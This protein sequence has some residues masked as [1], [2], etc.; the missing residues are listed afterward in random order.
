[1]ENGLFFTI[2]L[3]AG[4]Q[5]NLTLLRDL[6]EQRHCLTAAVSVE[7]HERI[8]DYKRAL[9]AFR[10]NFKGYFANFLADTILLSKNVQL[11]R[12]RRCGR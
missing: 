9:R 12:R 8:V 5:Y 3:I 10:H 4:K 2:D 6:L 11:I 1:M 7:I